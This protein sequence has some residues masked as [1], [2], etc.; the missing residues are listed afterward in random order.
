MS[1]NIE[2]RSAFKIW[3]A[4]LLSIL[5]LNAQI[6]LPNKIL[7]VSPGGSGTITVSI[8]GSNIGSFEVSVDCDSSVIEFTNLTQRNVSGA[9]IVS[10]FKKDTASISGFATG[11]S[12]FNGGTIATIRYTAVGQP[13]SYSDINCGGS[14]YSFNPPYNSVGEPSVSPE[15]ITIDARTT[16]TT[17]SPPTT[18]EKIFYNLIISTIGEGT[19][20]PAPGTYTYEPGVTVELKA[21]PK[22]GWQFSEWTGPVVNPSAATTSTLMDENKTIAA[23]FVQVATTAPPTTTTQIPTTTTSAT[24]TTA[25]TVLPPTTTVP[26]TTSI[27]VNY[28][29][30]ISIDGSGTT[31]PSSGIHNYSGGSVVNLEAIPAQGWQF[32]GWIGDVNAPNA[33]KTSIILTS[34]KILVAKFTRI[35]ETDSLPPVITN[36]RVVNIKTTEADITWT[37]NELSDSQVEYWSSPSQF[38]SLDKTPA[39]NHSV[40]LFGLKSGTLYH[41]KTFSRDQAGNLAVSPEL[42]FITA[43]IGPIFATS[44]WNISFKGE[45]GNSVVITYLVE[46]QGDEAGKYS[47]ALTLNE[48]ALE[49]KELTISPGEQKS[50]SFTMDNIAEGTYQAKIGDSVTNFVLSGAQNAKSGTQS[51]SW[52]MIILW[53]CSIVAVMLLTVVAT[54]HT[55]RR[56]NTRAPA[57]LSSKESGNYSA[58]RTAVSSS[59][60][61]NDLLILESKRLSQDQE[62]ILKSPDLA[63]IR[64]AY[65]DIHYF[66][67]P[68]I[69]TIKAS[70]ILEIQSRIETKERISGE[71]SLGA[72]IF[73]VKSNAGE[74][75]M[76]LGKRQRGDLAVMFRGSYLIF[77]NQESAALLNGS[78]LD[79]HQKPEG[80][81]FSL[82][83]ADSLPN[84]SE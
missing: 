13:G 6:I 44:D 38:S 45:S 29:L 27:A 10:N 57:E 58:G 78:V 1:I 77:I 54:Q 20:T 26:P 11:S 67:D 8:S 23:R 30:S 3:I 61:K 71:K 2:K 43:N 48:N 52:I 60:E 34:N 49:N 82:S 16:T 5:G 35:P 47:A 56:S 79:F 64:V 81:T 37:T 80:E 31:V 36:F 9:A 39:T 28:S 15:R 73:G 65:K 4:V 83:R 63:G 7:A 84:S 33:V 76:V 25:T 46:N 75:R 24:P 69:F 40:H 17:T 21:T 62:R 41:Y 22:L 72:R 59:K 32:S 66:I 53:I 18:S 42:S 68:G 74:L 14:V 55:V 70:A 12:G 51:I 19:T 50:I